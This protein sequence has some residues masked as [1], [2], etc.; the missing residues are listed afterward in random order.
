M[1][2]MEKHADELKLHS[3][4][5]NKSL[6]FSLLKPLNVNL[7]KLQWKA[8]L[9]FYWF[10]LFIFLICKVCDGRLIFL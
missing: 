10:V 5:L 6:H 2:G 4:T 3:C 8:N 1:R 9:T 7:F